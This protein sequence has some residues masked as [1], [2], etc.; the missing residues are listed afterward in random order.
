[1]ATREELNRII[2]K[3]RIEQLRSEQGQQLSQGQAQQL[4]SQLGGQMPS[5]GPLPAG[6]QPGASIQQDYYTMSSTMRRREEIARRNAYQ[7]LI[8]AG[9]TPE[10]IGGALAFEEG[11]KPPSRAPQT[12]GTIAGS[13]LASKLIPGPVDDV[14][15][16]ARLARGLT[17]GGIVGFGG[18][19]GKATQMAIDPDM[20]FN[21]KELAKVFGEEAALEYV[22]L[23]VAPIGRR[24]I[25]GVKKTAIPGAK[26]MSESLAAAGRK[27]GL[28]KPITFLPAQFSD[29]SLIDTFQGIGEGALLGDAIFQAKRAQKLAGTD[30]IEG[31]AENISKG[32]KA[33]TVDEV[34][35]LLVD[36]IEDRAILHK[37]AAGKLYS[38]L[39][40]A[41][42]GAKIDM[43]PIHRL[44]L[45]KIERFGRAGNVGISD[46]VLN[47]LKRIADIG[48]ETDNLISFETAQDLRSGLLSITRKGGSVLTPDKQAIRVGKELTQAM[49]GAI[50]DTAKSISPEVEAMRRQ[51]HR[52]YKAGKDRFENKTIRTLMKQLDDPALSKPD[53]ANVIFRSRT[54]INRVRKAA[55]KDLFQKAKGAWVQNIIRESMIPDPSD[56]RGIGDPVG[57]RILKQFNGIGQE[58]LDIAFTKAEQFNIRDSA[59]IMA[60]IQKETGGH[61]GAL[62]FVQGA[63]LAGVIAAPFVPGEKTGQAISGS[64]AMLL[65]GPAVLGKLMTKPAFSK[66]LKEGYRAT[67]GTQQAVAI[68]ARLVRNVMKARRE[69]AEARRKEEKEREG[70]RFRRGQPTAQQLMRGGTFR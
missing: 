35:S 15:I 22:T 19:A 33:R 40:V 55:G 7:Q 53:V 36:S 2:L 21:V 62:R 28:K 29:D 48:N 8:G 45:Q 46:E 41:A 47:N 70:E 37:V 66:L 24:L 20:D 17:K 60:I 61:A 67:P 65:I 44:A 42:E 59:R 43:T 68:T 10:R 1:M 9:Y 51:A 63:A 52:F 31:I 13:V 25:G 12:I 39:D 16:G 6:P 11:I 3:K 64:S 5:I 69:V 23:G 49:D 34:A 27:L 54:N 18:V 58:A 30:I 4:F 32:A 26:R 14:A 50:A 38:A 57:K 56:L